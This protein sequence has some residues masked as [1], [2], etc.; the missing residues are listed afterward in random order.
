MQ[1][2]VVLLLV[3]LAL[4]G[5]SGKGGA[6]DVSE[7]DVTVAIADTLSTGSMVLKGAYLRNA[8]GWA[9]VLGN[10]TAF[11]FAGQGANVTGNGSA[12]A[13]EYDRLRLLFSSVKLA[14][15]QALLTQ[16]G[17]E[18]AINVTVPANG[19]TAVF[20]AF[21][22]PDSFF[23]SAQGLA[24]TPVLSRLVVV[25]DG[26]E[27][28]RLE[29]SEI[30][31]GS[32]K[33]PV[34]RMRIFDPTG[35]EVF[36]STFIADSPEDF[37]IGNA[38]NLTLSAT[39]SE[40]L[41]PGASIASHVWDVDGET[42][43]G[44]TVVW[45]APIN[46]GKFTIRLTVEDSEGNADSQ[47]VQVALKPGVQSRTVTIMGEATGAGGT[48]GVEEH[49]FQVNSTELDGAPANLTHVRLVLTPGSATIPT[50]D[51]DV[52]LDDAA[53]KRIG[54]QTG[55]GSQHT[56]DTDVSGVASGEWKVRVIPDPGVGATYTV[57][58]TL[59]WKGVNLE[60]EAFLKDYDDGHSHEH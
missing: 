23:E 59:T 39:A 15:R 1:R 18:V 2:L 8:D 44:N 34:A 19:A 50:A 14:G 7:G 25:V 24:F 53:A 48:N 16:S 26:V 11:T 10:D 49:L 33:A 29:A 40:A 54:S 17:V 45:Q 3:G 55:S 30:S 52:T 13:G 4:A 57:T 46:G 28:L 32:G 12:P 42:L 35:L 51:L 21:A 58:I 6:G 56:I 36:A 38:G 27:T 60:L 31:T 5:C 41:Q 9:A 20:L 47:T 22:W 37:V 43:T